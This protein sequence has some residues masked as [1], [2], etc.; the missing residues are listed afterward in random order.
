MLVLFSSPIRL[1]I[2]LTSPTH[3]LRTGLLERVF[4]PPSLLDLSS[5]F[6]EDERSE[7]VTSLAFRY[8]L[9][10]SPPKTMVPYPPYYAR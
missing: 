7:I 10:Y 8:P 6:R 2:T 5:P 3:V 9:P 4:G 1:E